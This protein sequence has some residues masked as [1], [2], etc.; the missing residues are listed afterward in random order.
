MKL[1]KFGLGL[2]SG[3]SFIAVF[4]LTNK[5]VLAQ[6]V[7]ADVG[8]QYNISGSRVPTDRTNDVEF[9]GNGKCRGNTNVTTGVQGNVGGNGRVRQHRRVRNTINGNGEYGQKPVRVQSGVKVDVYN[10]ADNYQY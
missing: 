4:S 1:T 8:V 2:L 9:G 6:C 10:P 3:C 7:Q 5:P